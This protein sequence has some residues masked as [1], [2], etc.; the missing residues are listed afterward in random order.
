MIKKGLAVRYAAMAGTAGSPIVNP[1][2]YIEKT[3]ALSYDVPRLSRSDMDSLIAD[4]SLPLAI[5]ESHRKLIRIALGTNPRRVKR[6]LNL[7]GVEL[8]LAGM[9][10]ARGRPTPAA[11]SGGDNPV[12]LGTLLKTMLI[13]YR[14]SSLLRAGADDS[15]LLFTLEEAATAYRK[16]AE[17]GLA[18][19]KSS[20]GLK[21]VD[22]PADVA[23]LQHYEEFWALMAA[24]PNL[25][26]RKPAV[27]ELMDWFRNSGMGEPP[28][29]AEET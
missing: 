15:N 19:A 1:D 2:E 22:M 18:D 8:R 14:Y 27:G 11:F 26:S 9:M 16:D 24:G 25:A 29:S 5:D 4:A 12:L 10:A 17:K 13:G 6:F 20:R 28:G 7:F 21:L 3:I 23:A